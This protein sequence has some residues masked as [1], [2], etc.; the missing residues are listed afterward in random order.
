MMMMGDWH[1]VKYRAKYHASQVF[2][3]SATAAA[4]AAAALKRSRTS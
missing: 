1:D 2:N 3:S 4:A